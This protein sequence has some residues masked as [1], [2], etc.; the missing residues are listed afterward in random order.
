[1]EV[2]QVFASRV[3]SPQWPVALVSFPFRTPN[4]SGFIREV[5]VERVGYPEKSLGDSLTGRVSIFRYLSEEQKG[6]LLDEAAQLWDSH[7][8]CESPRVAVKWR[9]WQKEREK[10]VLSTEVFSMK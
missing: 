4:G 5:T 3:L 9:E 10:R 1:M 6:T 8:T 7:W 2:L